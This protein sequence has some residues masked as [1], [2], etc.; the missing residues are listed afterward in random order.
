MGGLEGRYIPNIREMLQKCTK[1]TKMHKLM[2]LH[3]SPFPFDFRPIT[4]ET[5]A[6]DEEKKKVCTAGS[7][8]STV[9][10]ETV[11]STHPVV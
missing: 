6:Y 11:D 3:K 9:Y 1:I 5:A 8:K 2:A 4:S 10:M 7:V